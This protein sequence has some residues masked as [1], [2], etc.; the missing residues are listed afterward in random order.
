MRLFRKECGKIW[1][2][3]IL[4]VI[5]AFSLV[6]F[7]QFCHRFCNYPHFGFGNDTIDQ[8]TF[9]AYLVATEMLEEYGPT[10]EPEERLDAEK[11]QEENYRKLD[12]FVQGKAAYEEEGIGSGKDLWQFQQGQGQFEE[13]FQK[14][15]TGEGAEMD[16]WKEKQRRLVYP[17][18]FGDPMAP[19][20]GP[21]LVATDYAMGKLQALDQILTS[22]DL[23]ESGE[24]QRLMEGNPAKDIVERVEDLTQSKECRTLFYPGIARHTYSY[25]AY[26]AVLML[27]SNF[28]LILPYQ[29]RDQ[30][31]GIVPLQCSGKIGRRLFQT[32]FFTIV[33]SSLFLGLTQLGL[34]TFLFFFKNDFSMFFSLKIT[35]AIEWSWFDLTYFHWLCLLLAL[36]LLLTVAGGILF[37]AISH[38]SRDAISALAKA[39]PLLG[40]LS[41]LGYHMADTFLYLRNVVC[42]MLGLGIVGAELYYSM[43]VLLLAGGTFIALYRRWQRRDL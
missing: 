24:M 13:A 25:F 19:D 7:F 40:M 16:A 18:L 20:G 35:A 12:P 5:T 21:V 39:L 37:F 33:G 17:L 3:G 26:G 14:A 6:F 28:I 32:Q 30:V 10:L 29:V 27:I 36:L 34:L 15:I 31:S 1:R 41:F 4:L 22:W 2:P 8:N 42:Q 43:V 23:F 38:L 9:P 11:Y